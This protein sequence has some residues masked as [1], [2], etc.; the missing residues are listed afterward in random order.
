MAFNVT[1]G[2]GG[3]ISTNGQTLSLR[4]TSPYNVFTVGVLGHPEAEWVF[5]SETSWTINGIQLRQ[6]LT[7]LTIQ[8]L[9]RD[10]N[11][12]HTDAVN[13]NKSG[14]ARPVVE[15]DS[16]PDSFNVSVADDL[17]LDATGSYDP[18]GSNLSFSWSVNPEAGAILTNPTVD[19]SEVIFGNPGLY[20]ITVTASDANG[21]GY[22]EM[23]EVSVYADSG[24]SPFTDRL[25]ESW[26]TLENMEVRHDYSGD[27]WYSLNDR[28]G[29]LVVKLGDSAPTPLT[30]SNPSH[31]VMWR[32]VPD[33]VDF[34][35][36]TDMTLD[37]VQR[38]D[39]IAGLIL[40]IQEGA[41]SSRYV[42]GMEDGNALRIKRSSGGSYTQ[43]YNRSYSGGT[44]VI[45]I[46]R[47]GRSLRFERRLEP[48]VW[49]TI[50]SRVMP[51]ASTMGRGGLFAAN[52]T[53][54]A[55]RFRFDY[56]MV[57]DPSVSSPA[58]NHLRVTELMYEPTG[59]INLE[60][61]ELVN[62]GNTPLNLDGVSFDGG[63]PFDA[64]TFSALT[65]DPDEHAVLV[66]DTATFQAEYG[67]AVRIMGE[68]TGGSL[69]NSG[70]KIVLR[71]D[72]GN[73]IHDFNYDT[74]A[75]WP[76]T[77]AGQ[78][79]S[80]EVIDIEGDYN[81]PANWRASA[82]VGGTP[83]AG[84]LLDT[85]GDGLSDTDEAL[86]GTNPLRPDTDSDGALDGAEVQAGTDPL[87]ASSIF[88]IIRLSRNPVT[89][90]L[91][92]TWNSVPGK[93]YTLEASSD[94]V[95]WVDASS[96]ILATGTSTSQL[97][98]AAAGQERRFYRARV[99]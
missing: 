52:D 95:N 39:F 56:V 98:P 35:L 94:M 96:G 3:T 71:D 13:V 2:G 49:T 4:G 1:S 64:F 53:A 67:G 68:W 7:T 10:G 23:R 45:R 61:V 16:R 69:S 66:A 54:R 46:R 84:V 89:G 34:T 28:P 25:L 85:D 62:T 78:G 15:V 58:V 90:F 81:D 20:E 82:V 86:A 6:G 22:S 57:I 93:S 14:N 9:D 99:E 27:S 75:P 47:E 30:G 72:A 8:G 21:E 80:L 31:P 36:Q 17:D 74:V 12:V 50:Y 59:G 24:W 11:V 87:D 29:N 40:E 32:E 44:A 43:L 97:D 42:F 73:I 60:F 65:L 51:V 19:T 91:T 26:W 76:V 92:A 77:P 18:E 37:S 83:G 70:E 79:P 63:D 5:N 88:R 33:S 41:T 38:G 55:A 48:G